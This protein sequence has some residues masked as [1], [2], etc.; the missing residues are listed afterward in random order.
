MLTVRV[1]S[2]LIPDV[3]G[4]ISFDAVLSAIEPVL[5]GEGR[6]VTGVRINGVEE[7]AFRDAIT[8]TRTLAD[9]DQM[10]LVTATAAALS[11]G[12]LADA[13]HFL[14]DLTGTARA[15]ARHLRDDDITEIHAGLG[16]LAEGLAMLTALILRADDWARESG[17]ARTGWLG[18]DVSAVET[19][20]E[21]LGEAAATGAWHAVADVLDRDLAEA[22]D[23]WRTRLAAGL[24]AVE[25][26]SVSTTA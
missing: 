5:A 9:G 6:I 7:P 13:V 16:S 23:A 10:D 3:F 17:L 18:E 20:V 26:A 12:A 11:A 15:M 2:V 25:R 14:P 1:D 4:P 21:R 8:R 22:L 24:A 19:A